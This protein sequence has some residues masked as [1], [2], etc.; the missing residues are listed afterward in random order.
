MTGCMKLLSMVHGSSQGR[1]ASS[2]AKNNSN[3]SS[4]KQSSINSKAA[5]IAKTSSMVPTPSS[6][7]VTSSSIIYPSVSSTIIKSSYTELDLEGGWYCSE[8]A[9]GTVIVMEGFDNKGLTDPDTGKYIRDTYC[10]MN[11]LYNQ[12]IGGV[13]GETKT[14]DCSFDI[15]FGGNYEMT[16]TFVDSNTIQQTCTGRTNIATFKRIDTA[17]AK[18][19]LSLPQ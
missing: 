3:V 18:N 12:V 8:S 5:S 14:G 1:S 16:C 11:N 17:T 4:Q 2:S 10:Y 15:V 13:S 6:S 9:G 7:S 19:M